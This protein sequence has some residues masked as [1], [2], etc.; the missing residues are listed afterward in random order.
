MPSPGN[1]TIFLG[2]AATFGL[3]LGVALGLALIVCALI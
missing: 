3:A 2:F 1:S